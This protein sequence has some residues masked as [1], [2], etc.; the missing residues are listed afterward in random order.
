M[1]VMGI[2]IEPSI[3]ERNLLKHWSWIGA[4]ACRYNEAAPEAA[5]SS[6]F[7]RTRALGFVVGNRRAIHPPTP[8]AT[9]SGFAARM[10]GRLSFSCRKLYRR[11]LLVLR[12]QRYYGMLTGFFR[13]EDPHR[14]PEAPTSSSEPLGVLVARANVM[15]AG[16]VKK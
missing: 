4:V 13:W 16:V 15:C 8:S 2:V 3:L 5:I 11:E 12:P 6:S 10:W 1:P 14:K 9:A 7:G